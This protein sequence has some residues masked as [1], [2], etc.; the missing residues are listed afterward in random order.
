VTD[1]VP[2]QVQQLT[3]H[4]IKAQALLQQLSASLVKYRAHVIEIK[5]IYAAPMEQ[6]RFPYSNTCED[7]FIQWLEYEKSH[8]LKRYLEMNLRRDD[9]REHH[10]V[11]FVL[12]IC[13]LAVIFSQFY[14]INRRIDLLVKGRWLLQETLI[15]GFVKNYFGPAFN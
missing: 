15:F 3:E 14:V 12:L 13:T 6:H 4:P 11:N 2:V 1:M 7:I 10:V 9:R 8:P 5:E